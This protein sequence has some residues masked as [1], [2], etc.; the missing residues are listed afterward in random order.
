MTEKETLSVALLPAI[1]DAEQDADLSPTV[2]VSTASADWDAMP[3]ASV[4][5]GARVIPCVPTINGDGD[6]N[7]GLS[8]GGV[9]SSVKFSAATLLRFPARSV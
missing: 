3:E 4:A 8:C 9:V 6:E 5:F 1:S 7:V 2:D